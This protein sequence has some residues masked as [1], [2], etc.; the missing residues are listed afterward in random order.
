M[1]NQNPGHPPTLTCVH[2]AG[3]KT[4]EETFGPLEDHRQWV[5][6]RMRAAY[7]LL[8]AKPPTFASPQPELPKKLWYWNGLHQSTHSVGSAIAPNP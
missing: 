1:A 6:L 8:N 3:L 7:F 5:F 2:S 4:S